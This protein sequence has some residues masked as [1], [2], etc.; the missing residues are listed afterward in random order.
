MQSTSSII[1]KAPNNFLLVQAKGGFFGSLVYRIIAGTSSEFIWKPEFTGCNEDLSPL[2]WPKLTEGFN[3]YE[4]SKNRTYTWFKENHLAT[5]HISHKLL[6]NSEPIDVIKHF[7]KNKILLLKTHDM[8]AHTKFCCK[9]VRIVGSIKNITELYGNDTTVRKHH[10]V[11][12]P[13]TIGDNIYNL[14]IESLMNSDFSIFLDE[15][16]SLCAFL[17]V[18]CNVNNVR[19]F[20]LLLRDK[21]KRYRLTL[22]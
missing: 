11:T 15:Y 1:N 22:P 7:D 9:I 19:Q 17:N 21:L 8:E 10:E 5:A 2:E 14:N 20:I 6:E 18:S 4:L 16:L 12:I 3:I 13:E